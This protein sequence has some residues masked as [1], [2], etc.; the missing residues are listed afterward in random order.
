MP[1]APHF[2]LRFDRD[3]T[4]ECGAELL[5][6]ITC[7]D[8]VE[9][10]KGQELYRS[11]CAKA[12]WQEYVDH[13]KDETPVTVKPRYLF[14][15][16][17]QIDQ[18]VAFVGRRLGERMVA[19]RMAIP[20]LHHAD[21]GSYGH[22][23]ASI[24]RPSLNQLAKFVLQD[25]RKSDE[26]NVLKRCWRPSRRVIHLCGAAAIIG[27]ERCRAGLANALQVF[28]VNEKFVREVVRLGDV[29]RARAARDPKFPVPAAELI[30]VTASPPG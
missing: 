10:E 26:A 14:R 24:E 28:L 20:F 2:E 27:Q 21:T 4:Y 12:L 13:P 8:D 7:P 18:D 23:P 1:E 6:I 11:L 5:L 30:R 29:L 15:D 16:L 19:G 25:A 3:T 22:L 9:T 17:A